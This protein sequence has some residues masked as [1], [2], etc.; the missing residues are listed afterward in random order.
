M[1]KW[2]IDSGEMVSYFPKVFR[3]EL[4]KDIYNFRWRDSRKLYILK[5]IKDYEVINNI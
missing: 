5:M 4:T 3:K 2:R 1:F